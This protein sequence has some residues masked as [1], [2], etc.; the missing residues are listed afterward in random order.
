MTSQNFSALLGVFKS[1][2]SKKSCG[3]L[4]LWRSET[5]VILVPVEVSLPGLPS[6][7][8]GVGW[9][10]EKVVSKPSLSQ[11]LHISMLANKNSK[12]LQ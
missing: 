8:A 3:P 11:L 5:D 2:F 7:K 1:W 9:T 12:D 4:S 6:S 10:A